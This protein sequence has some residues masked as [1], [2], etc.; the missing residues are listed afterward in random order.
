[1]THVVYLIN[2]L[3]ILILQNQTPFEMVYDKPLTF[4]NLQYLILYVVFLPWNNI[5]LKLIN[6]SS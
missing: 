6:G 4:L 1:M 2:I 3:P 5:V